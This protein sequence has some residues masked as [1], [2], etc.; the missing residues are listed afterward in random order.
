[1]TARC[2]GITGTPTLAA[3]CFTSR[4]ETRG[5]GGGR[6]WRVL[7][8]VVAAIDADQHLDL[9]V[10]RGEIGIVHGPVEAQPITRVRLEIVG[11][12]AQRDAAPVIGAPAEHARPPPLELAG[13]IF[14]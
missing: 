13:G 14:G 11:T 3:R 6:A 2:I 9:V 10:I 8:V 7:H 1:M 5:F 4:S 12:V